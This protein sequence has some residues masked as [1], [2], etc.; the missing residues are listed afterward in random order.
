MSLLDQN[1]Q[2]VSALF[3]ALSSHRLEPLSSLFDPSFPGGLSA[4]ES[5]A[6]ALIRA[7]P[8]I[9]YT[10]PSLVAEDDRVAVRFQWVG[11]HRGVFRAFAA[12]GARV[13]STGLALFT[14][15]AG[16]ITAIEL[17]TDRLGF[18]QQIGALPENPAAGGPVAAPVVDPGRASGAV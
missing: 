2:T 6:T 12:T 7:F 11:T 4:F 17:E 14:L 16:L 1:K 3:D 18:L 5:T 13:T 10:L 8:D 9:Q 15:R